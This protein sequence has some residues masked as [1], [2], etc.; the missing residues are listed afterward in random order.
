MGCNS[1]VSSA[2]RNRLEGNKER[3]EATSLMKI[4]KRSGSKTDSWGLPEKKTRVGADVQLL[5][6]TGCVRQER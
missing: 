2:Y 5:T 1:R 6:L 3:M 4:M